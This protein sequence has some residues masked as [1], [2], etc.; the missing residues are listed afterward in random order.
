MGHFMQL[1]YNLDIQ[2]WYASQFPSDGQGFLQPRGDICESIIPRG[3]RVLPADVWEAVDAFFHR[4]ELEDR[5]NGGA[6]NDQEMSTD[7]EAAVTV[8]KLRVSDPVA[9]VSLQQAVHDT[10]VPATALRPQEPEELHYDS[11][12]SVLDLDEEYPGLGE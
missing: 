11:D 7:T 10:L 4:E 12:D 6:D 3:F 2:G 5:A 9:T 1:Y 8:R